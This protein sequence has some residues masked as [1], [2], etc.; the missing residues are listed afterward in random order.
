MSSVA[1]AISL[2]YN[3]LCVVDCVLCVVYFLLCAVCY[4][5]CT[6]LFAVYGCVLSCVPCSEV[7][8]D[9]IYGGRTAV[10][11]V[12]LCSSH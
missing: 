11:Y 1:P 12:G 3:R 6:A 2:F 9:G 4:L 8:I 7:A 5:L 10:V